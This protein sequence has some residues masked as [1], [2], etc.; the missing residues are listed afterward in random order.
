MQKWKEDPNLYNAPRKD[1][2]KQ[3]D[4]YDTYVKNFLSEDPVKD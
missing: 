2:I 3:I 4:Y 1:G